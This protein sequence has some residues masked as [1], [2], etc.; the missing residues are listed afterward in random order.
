VRRAFTGTAP[1]RAAL[2]W[3]ALAWAALAWA[4]G[5]GL[6]LGWSV[7]SRSLLLVLLAGALAAMNGY[8]K[9]YSP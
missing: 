6:L 4:A 5:L 9:A 3:A 1:T 7:H 8:S 2:T